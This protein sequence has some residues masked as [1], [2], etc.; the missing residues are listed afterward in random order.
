MTN[1]EKFN[2][3]REFIRMK[4]RDHPEFTW[5]GSINHFHPRVGKIGVLFELSEKGK[6]Q[7][8][9]FRNSIA[10]AKLTEIEI[11]E[12]ADIFRRQLNHD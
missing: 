6:V 9:R 7:P 4:F 3:Q 2:A 5:S 8:T 10:E 12:M 11:D 1:F